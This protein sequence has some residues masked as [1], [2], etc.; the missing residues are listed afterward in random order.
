[1]LDSR[2]LKSAMFAPPCWWAVATAS[3]LRA[4]PTLP[5]ARPKIKRSGRWRRRASPAATAAA[6]A[7]PPAPPPPPPRA[8]AL[9][10]SA[11]GGRAAA[12][13]DLDRRHVA[14]HVV[15]LGHLLG[16]HHDVRGRLGIGEG[17]VGGVGPGGGCPRAS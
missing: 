3:L 15:H 12:H 11:R 4:P 13:A 8:P 7:A 5:P 6:T 1:M 17:V 2:L 9:P 16:V 10:R 14:V